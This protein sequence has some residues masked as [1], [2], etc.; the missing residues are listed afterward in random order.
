MHGGGTSLV[1]SILDALG[2]NMHYNP[3]A[4]VKNYLNYEDTGF[5]RI[6]AKIIRGA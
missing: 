1:A 6:N 2:V 3:R 4:Q 5:V